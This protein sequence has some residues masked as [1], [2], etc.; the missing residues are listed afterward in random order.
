MKVLLSSLSLIVFLCLG[1]K[2]EAEAI[3]SPTVEAVNVQFLIS[4]TP[5]K[6]QPMTFTEDTVKNLVYH[7][8]NSDGFRVR[9]FNGHLS[10]SALST[11]LKGHLE[12]G[13]YKFVFF[14]A[15]QPLDLHLADGPA[16]IESFVYAGNFSVYH[17]VVEIN[18]EANAINQAVLLD[19]LNASLEIN[20]LDESIPENVASIEV[21]WTDNKYI[22]FD[23]SSFT[24]ARKQ[25]NLVVTNQI[26]NAKVA[27][28]ETIIFNTSAPFSVHVNYIDKTGKHVSGQEIANVRC[29][30]NQRTAVS[31]YLFN[32]STPN[33]FKAS[34][35]A[36]PEKASAKLSL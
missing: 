26:R 36:I 14:S 10:Q 9:N 30:K 25:K 7:I 6:S 16:E 34:I 17:K 1:C 33:E 27:R 13:K 5:Q 32:A 35:N 3:P 12:P 22:G 28:I 18:I 19:K 31:G 23:G 24:S 2:K 8:Y 15:S 29:L 4:H 11:E 20:L 21:I